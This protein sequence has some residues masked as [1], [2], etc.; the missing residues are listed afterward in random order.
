MDDLAAGSS[1]P[2]APVAVSPELEEQQVVQEG[3]RIP[4][5]SEISGSDTSYGG[6]DTQVWLSNLAETADNFFF[7]HQPSFSEPETEVD[8]NAVV[9]GKTVEEAVDKHT[10]FDFYFDPYHIA[11]T[12]NPI[13]DV[14]DTLNHGDLQFR[15]SPVPPSGTYVS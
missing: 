11:E 7:T 1:S 12:E 4:T 10:N 14:D 15:G 13:F 2:L 5:S 6:F 9:F 3:D 8:L